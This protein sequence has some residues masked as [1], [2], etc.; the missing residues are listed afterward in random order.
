MAG[1]PFEPTLAAAAAG[2]DEAAALEAL[3]AALAA[4]LVRATDQPRRFSFRHPLVR[5]AVYE[6]AG[7]GWKLAAHARAAETLAARGATARERAHH[8]A[9]AAQPGDTDAVA[10]LALAGEQTA[11]AAPA[12]AAG[13]Y[14]AALRLLPESPEHDGRRL[15]LLGAQASALASGGRAVEARDVLRQ[16]LAR[17]PPDAAAERVE[18]AATLAELQALWTQQPDEARALLEAE[19]AALGDLAPGLAAAL[20]LVMVRERAVHGDHAAAEML[21]DE[22]RA[23]AR[24]AGDPALEAEAVATAADAAHCRLRGDDPEALA[25]VDLKIAQAA[26]LVDALSDERVAERLQMLF[27]LSVAWVFT[28]RFEPARSLAE[29]GVRVARQSGQGLFAPAF[30]CLRG[31]V[32]AELGRLDAAEADEEEALESAL[33]S[34]NVQ[35]T[36]WTSI[37]LSRTALARGRIEAALEHGQAA[38]DVLGLVEYSQAGYAVA[39]AR[40]AAGDPQGARAVLEEF[41]WVHPALW[42]LDRLRAAEVAVRVLLALGQVEEAEAWAKRIPAE[43]GGRQAGVFGAIAGHAEAAVLLAQEAA[44]RAAEVALAAAAA[45]EEGNSPLWAGRCRTLAGTALVASGRGDDARR[46]LRQA[47]A[48]LD[49]RGAWGYRDEALR[50]LRRLGDRPRPTSASLPEGRDS[51]GRL[52]TLTPREREVALLVATAQTNAQIA[53][54]L[55]LSESTVEKHVSR[56]LAKLGLGSRAGIVRLLA[57]DAPPS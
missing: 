26:E 27:W 13:W 35:V 39:D 5:R 21:A 57:E 48:E 3:D 2:M 19:R 29:R 20:T 24:A 7:G 56:V 10:L 23:L 8:V 42:T 50:E 34:G 28:G 53:S 41:G 51:G 52:G 54:Q 45:G 46:E 33:L 32:D 44:P 40:L 55:H 15:A 4:D 18:V 17:L 37:A 11:L 30:V 1:D 31:W 43:G 25:A 16:L 49:A 22:A 9:R 12:T 38:W 14:A 36:Y 47:A 6:A